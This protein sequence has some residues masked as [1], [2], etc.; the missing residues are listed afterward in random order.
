M[1]DLLLAGF[2]LVVFLV[3]LGGV[4]WGRQRKKGKN[5]EEKRR[6]KYIWI[7]QGREK[8]RKRNSII[9]RV[10]KATKQTGGR[11]KHGFWKYLRRFEEMISQIQFSL[12]YSHVHFQAPKLQWSVVHPKTSHACTCASICVRV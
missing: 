5:V 2:F 4:I 8:D 10:Q 1:E 7:R 3:S 6:E 11:I 9:A 12:C